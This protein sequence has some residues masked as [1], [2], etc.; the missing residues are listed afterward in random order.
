MD[1]PQS[2]H[3][4]LARLAAAYDQICSRWSRGELNAADARGQISALVARDDNGTHWTINPTDGNWQYRTRT[5]EWRAGDPPTFGYATP[6]AFELTRES[7]A[8]NP[9][10]RI[11][12]Y[13]VDESL[14]YPPTSLAGSTRRSEHPEPERFVSRFLATP[15]QRVVAVLLALVLLLLAYLAVGYLSGEPETPPAEAPAPPAALVVESSEHL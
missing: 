4:N 1:Q 5:G 8:F 13:E 6:T 14:L 7:G 15:T 12:F 11:S 2:L 3:P 10:N 9:D